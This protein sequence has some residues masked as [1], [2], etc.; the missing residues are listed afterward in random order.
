MKSDTES[1][2]ERRWVVV[3]IDGRY[4]TLGL[5]SDP[6][7]KEIALAEEALRM[8]NLSGWLAIMEGN[9]WVGVAP[10]L[11][12]VRPLASPGTAF[13]DAAEACIAVILDKRAEA[14]G[15]DNGSVA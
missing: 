10:R 1:S 9:P 14:S 2:R 11:L 6:S 15:G 4:V 13:A 3:A 7:E 8:Q 12:E 5:N